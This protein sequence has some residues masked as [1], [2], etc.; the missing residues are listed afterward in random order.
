MFPGG[1]Q[2]PRDG[3]RDVEDSLHHA[4]FTF[5]IILRGERLAN[6]RECAIPHYRRTF[7]NGE[8]VSASGE[9]HSE[10]ARQG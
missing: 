10:P 3:E 1:E 5:F 8:Y 7:M 4:H 9:S 6:G 2:G